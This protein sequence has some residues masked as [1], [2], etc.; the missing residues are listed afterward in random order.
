M[1]TLQ[2]SIITAT[3][4]AAVGVG[5]YEARQ[6]AKL[7]AANQELQKQQTPLTEEIRQLRASNEA[8]SNR[9]NDIGEANKLAAAQFNELLKL[10]GQAGQN[11]AALDQ[12]TQLQRQVAQKS[13]QKTNSWGNFADTFAAQL[14]KSVIKAQQ[15]QVARLEKMLNL[16]GD[17]ST[18]ISNILQNIN[19]TQLLMMSGK[20]L[21]PQQLQPL[22][23]EPD[24][25]IKA[26]LTPDQL[27]VYQADVQAQRIDSAKTSSELMA[28]AIA[29]DLDLPAAQ[30]EQVQTALY[31]LY[32]NDLTDRNQ[33][34]AAAAVHSGRSMDM[35]ELSTLGQQLQLE[36]TLNVLQPIL[37]AEQL[38]AYRN[39]EMDR[40]NGRSH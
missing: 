30:K 39:K 1:T 4:A 31:Q 32:A 10:R 28:G 37:T 3:L 40:I 14:Q 25:E 20:K 13:G 9:L 38:D 24:A 6:A 21:T 34:A 27:A 35:R 5:I 17:Q 36:K 33:A 16:T 7:S 26:L 15:A 19:E 18:A 29:K 12:L 8:L 2:K 23:G 11:R 22:A